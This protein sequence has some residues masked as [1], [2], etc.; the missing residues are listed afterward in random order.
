MK[1][2]IVSNPDMLYT[3]MMHIQS[4]AQECVYEQVDNVNNRRHI[5]E[6]TCGIVGG[7][8]KLQERLNYG[9]LFWR[10]F[11]SSSSNGTSTSDD[12]EGDMTM[13]AFRMGTVAEKSPLCSFPT[14]CAVCR[15]IKLANFVNI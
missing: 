12:K 4:D 6:M 13:T 15:S 2:K 1:D 10:L 5:S 3:M 7:Y 14:T 11:E 9:R 8:F